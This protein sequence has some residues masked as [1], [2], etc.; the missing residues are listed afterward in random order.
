MYES[1]RTSLHMLI[2]QTFLQGNVPLNK[3][4]KL[5]AFSVE[6]HNYLKF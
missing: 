3:M 2:L 5:T 6:K 4:K 1:T